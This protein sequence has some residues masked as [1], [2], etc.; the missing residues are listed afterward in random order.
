MKYLDLS[1]GYRLRGN[2]SFYNAGLLEV[3]RN[4][5]WGLVC[6]DSWDLTDAAVACKQLGFLR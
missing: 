3:Y 2:S 4:N 5:S 1:A 6:D